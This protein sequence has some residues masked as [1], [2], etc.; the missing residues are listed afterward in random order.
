MIQNS[1]V[2]L[3]N[4]VSLV[5]ENPG[6]STHSVVSSSTSSLVMLFFFSVDELFQFVH[7]F[8][9]FLSK[10]RFIEI[11]CFVS[12][13]LCPGY[14]FLLDIR[15]GYIDIKFP[16]VCSVRLSRIWVVSRFLVFHSLLQG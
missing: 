1:F 5:L 3:Y 13:L 4:L 2:A 12:I 6:S 9:G 8:L 15:V 11:L 16:F 7:L 10:F 14:A